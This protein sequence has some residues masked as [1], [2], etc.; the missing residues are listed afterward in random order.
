MQEVECEA[1]LFLV[2]VGP[3]LASFAVLLLCAKRRLILR[4]LMYAVV[5]IWSLPSCWAVDLFFC[6]VDGY[7]WQ[8]GHL[9]TSLDLSYL[10]GGAMIFDP[11]SI[12]S[13]VF[14]PTYGAFLLVFSASWRWL[15]IEDWRIA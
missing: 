15:D 14:I 5:A 7:F 10:I 2:F 12:P 1:A 6:C 11:D 9:P 3:L 13:F 8:H 4:L